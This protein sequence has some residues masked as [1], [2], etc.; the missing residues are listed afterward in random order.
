MA[1]RMNRRQLVSPAITL[2]SFVAAFALAS[3]L[4]ILPTS[5]TFTFLRMRSY[6]TKSQPAQT[7]SYGHSCHHLLHKITVLETDLTIDSYVTAFLE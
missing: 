3:V 7:I 5:P 4:Q 2:L 1:V 6:L